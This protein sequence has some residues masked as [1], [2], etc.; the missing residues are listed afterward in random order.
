MAHTVNYEEGNP[1]C[2]S[3]CSEGHRPLVELCVEPA[4]FSGR[5]TGRTREASPREMTEE[6]KAATGPRRRQGGGD[7][8][9]LR[10]GRLVCQR[11][12]KPSRGFQG[13][14]EREIC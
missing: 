12:P 3:S 5:C 8:A 6:E 1:A 9:F 4:V 14:E 10:G 13:R 2:L 7:L 11:Q